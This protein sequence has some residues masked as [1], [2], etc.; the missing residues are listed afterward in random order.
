MPTRDDS[1]PAAP[2]P[3]PVSKPGGRKPYTPP[4]L[5]RHGN[6]ERLTRGTLSGTNDSQP[7]HRH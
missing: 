5:I 2:A 7:T 6:V 1:N 4:R 3:E